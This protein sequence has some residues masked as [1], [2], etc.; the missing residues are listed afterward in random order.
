MVWGQHFDSQLG[1]C[2]SN[3]TG[4]FS[5]IYLIFKFL[6]DVTFQFSDINSFQCCNLIMQ[7]KLK[8]QFFGRKRKKILK[9]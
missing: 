9:N 6:K 7:K 5:M 3:T 1:K 8:I 4:P 2:P